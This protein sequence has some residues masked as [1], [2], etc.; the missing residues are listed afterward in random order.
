MSSVQKL[1][2]G[3]LLK[4]TVLVLKCLD[5]ILNNLSYYFIKMKHMCACVCIHVYMDWILMLCEF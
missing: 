4:Q 3:Q 1:F 2:I 5:D